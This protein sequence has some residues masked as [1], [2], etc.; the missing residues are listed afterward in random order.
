M[1]AQNK[2]AGDNLLAGVRGHGI[3]AREVGNSGVGMAFDGPILAVHRNAGEI[4]H[5]LVGTGQLVK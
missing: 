1:A 4:A 5:M 3:D 2:I